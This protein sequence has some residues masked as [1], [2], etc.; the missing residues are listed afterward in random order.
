M[1]KT[2][3]FNLVLDG[4]QVKNLEGVQEN[5][6][7]EDMLKYFRSGLLERWLEIRGYEEEFAAVKKIDLNDDNTTIIK[8]LIRIFNIPI[9]D[10]DM[11]KGLA[12]LE[13]LD[14]ANYLNAEYKKNAFEKKQI[15]D[16]YHSG[17]RALVYHMEEFRDDMALLKA[18]VIEMEKEYLELFILDYKALYYRLSRSAPKAIFAFLTRKIFREYWIGRCKD[19]MIYS[20]IKEQLL[21]IHRIEHILGE[22]LKI[23]R[24][25]STDQATWIFVEE[26]EIRVMVLR[27]EPNT[28]IRNAGKLSENWSFQDINLKFPLFEGLDYRCDNENDRL[29]YMEV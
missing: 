28:Y 1:A 26:A 10:E 15:I 24:R 5:F 25:T 12:V 20:D 22:D 18:D 6:S 21:P 16:D 3:K 17:Y 9:N 23:V 27:M 4:C 19:P 11:K 14:E 7:I 13:Y 8:R 2:I 29:L